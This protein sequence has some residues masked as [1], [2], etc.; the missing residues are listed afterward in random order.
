[1]SLKMIVSE[2]LFQITNVTTNVTFLCNRRV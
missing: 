1:M 2:S